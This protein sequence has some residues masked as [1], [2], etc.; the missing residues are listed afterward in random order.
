M[1]IAVAVDGEMGLECP[2]SASADEAQQWLIAQLADGLIQ[3][4][5][6]EPSP[7]ASEDPVQAIDALR[8]DV[9]L[10][11]DVSAGVRCD[12]EQ[13]GLQVVSGATGSARRALLEFITGGLSV[14][15]ARDSGHTHQH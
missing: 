13:C 7:L 1:R 8:V 15:S 10:C 3:G 6:Q 14:D 12:L 9:L 2:C 11:A 5:C 4:V